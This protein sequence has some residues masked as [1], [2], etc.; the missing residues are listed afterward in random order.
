LVTGKVHLLAGPRFTP[1]TSA[2]SGKLPRHVLRELDQIA[3]LLGG[4]KR[5]NCTA[6]SRGGQGV[7]RA[8]AR[9]ACR[10]LKRDGLKARY[11]A[12]GHGHS[13]RFA[14]HLVISFRF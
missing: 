6:Y 13:G 12:G 1:R 11:R 4:V 10:R 8:Q 5:V 2:T 9:T 3:K 7:A 14:G